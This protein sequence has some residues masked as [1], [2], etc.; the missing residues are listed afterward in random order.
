MH[1]FCSL[2]SFSFENNPAARE[3]SFTTFSAVYRL[4]STSLFSPTTAAAQSTI[5]GVESRLKTPSR[6]EIS[7]SFHPRAFTK[8]VKKRFVVS[9]DGFPPFAVPRNKM[10]NISLVIRVAR[11]NERNKIVELFDLPLPLDF[12]RRSASFTILQM[13]PHLATM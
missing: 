8:V 5:I 4:Q 11:A 12:G 13:I 9:V 1:P 2:R 10:K 3:K 7:L 6:L